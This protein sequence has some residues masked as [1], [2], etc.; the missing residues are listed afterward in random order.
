MQERTVP[1]GAGTPA[2]ARWRDNRRLEVALF[3]LFAVAVVAALVRAV[4]LGNRILVL[5][6]PRSTDFFD[7]AS[8]ADSFVTVTDVLLGLIVL[9]IVPCF[10][11]WCFRAAKNQEALARRPERLGPGWAI[12]GWFI[13]LANLVIPVLVIQDLWRGSDARIERGDPR[14]RIAE[15][16]WL[17]GWWWGLLVVSLLAFAGAPIDRRELDLAEARGANLLALVAML[18]VASSAVLAILVVRRLDER[19]LA[20]REAHVTAEPALRFDALA[21]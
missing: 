18:C 20:T 19:Q 5:D 6:D 21:R 4:A 17:V 2:G 14:W 11:V 7:R 9:A 15:R 12:G 16:S 13:P 1:V 10:I 8:D 3:V